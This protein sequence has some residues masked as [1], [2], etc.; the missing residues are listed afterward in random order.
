MTTTTIIHVPLETLRLSR[1]NIRRTGGANVANLA[2]SIR[3]DGLLQNLTV[4]RVPPDPASELDHFEVIAGGR[5]LRA[6][7]LLR[8]RGELSAEHQVPVAIVPANIATEVGIAEN[9]IREKMHPHD[10]FV[11]FR[12]LAVQGTGVETI[13]ARFGV[14]PLVVERRLRLANVAPELLRAFREDILTLDQMMAFAITDDWAAQLRVFE[15]DD[16]RR[17]PASYIRH[18]L[19]EREIHTNDDRVRFVGLDAYEQAGGPVRRDLFD[20]AGGGYV[21]DENLLDQLVEER[22]QREAETVRAE[23]WS[24]VH[25][26]RDKHFDFL[27]NC[28]RSEPRKRELNADEAAELETLNTTVAT[29]RDQIEALDDEQCVEAEH[30]L[31]LEHDA[32]EER[33]AQIHADL[34]TWSDRQKAKSGALLYISYNGKLKIE[35]GL[36]PLENTRAANTAATAATDP[37][38]NKPAAAPTLSEAL[39]RRLTAHRAIAMQ[40]MLMQRTDIALAALTYA[41]IAPHRCHTHVRSPIDVQCIN[42]FDDPR[43]LGHQDIADNTHYAHTRETLDDLFRTLGVPEHAATLWRWCLEQN[44]D[45]LCALLAATSV[46]ALDA[47]KGDLQPH[48]SDALAEALGLDMADYWKPTAATLF[49]ITP[50]AIGLEAVREVYGDAEA[51]RLEP[52]K[53]AEFAGECERMFAGTGWLPKPLRQPGYETPSPYGSKQKSPEGDTSDKAKAKAKP[54]PKPKSQAKKPAAKKAAAKK[55]PAKKTVVKK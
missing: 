16:P 48:P 35:R 31:V 19:T 5:R 52:K 23:G 18:Q 54:K 6:L 32:A 15:S 51:E 7:Q 27:S 17:L 50:K 13:A 14:T 2:A 3:V 11:A 37:D 4:A 53:K 49:S 42:H 20:D 33:I 45:T 43:R 47:I 12:D 38:G 25:I 34:Y 21:C 8:D 24:F 30:P 36:I 39:I 29:L 28:G 55:T 9:T 46:L 44:R 1:H 41:L 10:E 22:L 26:A 40:A